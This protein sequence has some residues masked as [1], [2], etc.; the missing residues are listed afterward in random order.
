MQ[1]LSSIIHSCI[2]SDRAKIY[3]TNMFSIRLLII[4]TILNVV[5]DL[6]SLVKMHEEMNL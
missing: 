3:F 2:N 4:F 1:V 5:Q 6:Q